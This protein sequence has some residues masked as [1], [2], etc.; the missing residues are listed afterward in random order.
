[1]QREAKRDAWVFDLDNTL[2]DPK[3]GILEQ[4]ESKM[5]LAIAK[6][7]DMDMSSARRL[8]EKYVL[9]F[10]D[11]LTPLMKHHN[12]DPVDFLN[13]VH[14]IDYSGLKKNTKVPMAIQA[15]EGRRLVFTNSTKKHAHTVLEHLGLTHVFES[16]FHI[17][18][19]GYIPKPMDETYK[20]FID[21]F[22]I[23]PEKS[24]FIDDMARNLEIPKNMGFQTVWITPDAVVGSSQKSHAHIDNI[25]AHI[26][27]FLDAVKDK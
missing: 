21:K 8:Y 11:S 4:I 20:K 5:P 19:G 24:I 14:D 13:F 16:V 1:M 3:C 27:D 26:M 15:L 10:G 9:R 23:I 22:S 6:V 7:L 17:A 12:I 2:Y 25:Y 18:D